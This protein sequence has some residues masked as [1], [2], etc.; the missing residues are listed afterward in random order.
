MK[1]KFNVMYIYMNPKGAVMQDATGQVLVQ[2]IHELLLSTCMR[3]SVHTLPTH[4]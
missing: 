4:R 2:L 1:M 3:I